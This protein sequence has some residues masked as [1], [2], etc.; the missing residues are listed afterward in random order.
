M[1]IIAR[2]QNDPEVM[3]RHRR[4]HDAYQNMTVEDI[5]PLA[6]GIFVKN[7]AVTYHI[8]PEE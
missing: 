4:R 7:N 1:G 5:K 6:K 3:E 2:S 8:L